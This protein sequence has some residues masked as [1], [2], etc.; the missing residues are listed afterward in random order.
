M[1]QSEFSHINKTDE[2]PSQNVCRRWKDRTVTG[3]T[4]ESRSFV[5]ISDSMVTTWNIPSPIRCLVLWG[6]QFCS[7]LVFSQSSCRKLDAREQ[8]SMF[9]S[10]E[11]ASCLYIAGSVAF[12][13]KIH[14]KPLLSRMGAN[15]PFFTCCTGAWKKKVLFYPTFHP[16]SGCFSVSL[17]N[18]GPTHWTNENH[19]S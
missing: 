19:G 10:Q 2:S 14:K 8:T 16:A 9:F 18:A 5:L 12:A 3:Q 4:M 17:L 6:R 13:S 15:L 1:F 7:P 11:A